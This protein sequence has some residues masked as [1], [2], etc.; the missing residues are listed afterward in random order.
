V[1]GPQ[2]SPDGWPRC[3]HCASWFRKPKL[4]GFSDRLC[5]VPDP[6][7]VDPLAGL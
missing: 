3:R 6:K 4:P 1:K 5:G 7:V 2:S